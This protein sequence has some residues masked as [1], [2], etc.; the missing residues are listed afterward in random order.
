MEDFYKYLGDIKDK[1]IIDWRNGVMEVED[2]RVIFR[3]G[4][5]SGEFVKKRVVFKKIIF[6]K[7]VNEFVFFIWLI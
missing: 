1:L 6:L 4:R 7:K 5:D 2:V 3:F